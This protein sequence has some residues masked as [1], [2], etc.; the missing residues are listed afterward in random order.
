[1]E[2]TYNTE[3]GNFLIKK[4]NREALL[5]AINKRYDKQYPELS[6]AF[7]DQGFV[8]SENDGDIVDVYLDQSYLGEQEEDFLMTV[9]TPFVQPGSYLVFAFGGSGGC[10]AFSW[11][12]DGKG[13]V[14]AKCEDVYPILATDLELLLPRLGDSHP[15]LYREFLKKYAPPHMVARLAKGD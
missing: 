13:G 10:F 1:M 9:L 6:S 5:E 2:H 11:W 12:S 3:H 4:H 7:G 8:F 14:K 15:E